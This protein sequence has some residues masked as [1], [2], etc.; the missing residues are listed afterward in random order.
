MTKAT[1]TKVRRIT[2]ATPTLVR[3]I[4]KVIPTKALLA[5]I[6]KQLK[7]RITVKVAILLIM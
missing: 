7:V 4:A 2:K 1:L 6:A 3:L 5:T